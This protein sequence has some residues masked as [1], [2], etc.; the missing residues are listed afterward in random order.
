MR[1]ASQ[2]HAIRVILE[3]QE[4]QALRV[5]LARGGVVYSERDTRLQERLESARR[6]VGWVDGD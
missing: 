1:T 6:H 4:E 3:V 5:V 2:N